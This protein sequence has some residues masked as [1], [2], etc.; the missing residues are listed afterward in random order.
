MYALPSWGLGL[1]TGPYDP[2]VH[3]A[4]SWYADPDHPAAT[5]ATLDELAEQQK[6]FA[7]W[8]LAH[9][10]TQA[11]GTNK[12]AFGPGLPTVADYQKVVREWTAEGKSQG[13]IQKA[14]AELVGLVNLIAETIPSGAARA[15][16][17][18]EGTGIRP[19]ISPVLLLGGGALLLLFLLRR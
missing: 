13:A 2:A 18:E 10:L 19:G 15:A 9:G 6:A 8:N 12:V 17:V 16:A 11:D 7:A 5:A 1:I 4:P 14:M 3:G